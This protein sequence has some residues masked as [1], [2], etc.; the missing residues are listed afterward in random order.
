MDVNSSF[1]I[2]GHSIALELLIQ[3]ILKQRLPNAYLFSG[4]SGI[5]KALTA[6]WLTHQVLELVDLP[7]RDDLRLHPNSLWIEPTTSHEGSLYTASQ[8]EERS[9]EFKS[10]AIRVDQVREISGR[11]AVRSLNGQRIV[12]VIEGVELLGESGANALLKNLEEP[13][14]GLFILIH[15][16]DG[17]K[18]ALPTI[19]SRCQQI[20]FNRLSLIDFQQIALRECPSLLEYPNL[21]ELAGGSIG[22]ALLAWN[23]AQSLPDLAREALNQFP[24]QEW[25]CFQ[26]AEVF[27]KLPV[28]QQQ[29]IIGLL[30]IHL[31]QQY[32]NS[33]QLNALQSAQQQ[34]QDSCH[35]PLV[36]QIL[37]MQLY[38][39]GLP[40]AVQ[41]P[42]SHA[43]CPARSESPEPPIQ[44]ISKG[45]RAKTVKPTEK[46]SAVKAEVACEQM[47]LF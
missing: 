38:Q 34:L 37:L 35:P 46:Q 31:W 43:E 6:R 23:T 26:Q 1:P 8:A 27:A 14:A 12:V 24:R 28:A 20:L 11:L 40:Y 42:R 47:P 45:R 5:G 4:A 36:W 10:P 19:L 44:Q 18:A 22:K 7:N 21:V 32:R 41:L 33:Q 15:H 25:Q 39:F 30:Q 17:G 3:A 29:W 9:I 13:G 2:V 16:L